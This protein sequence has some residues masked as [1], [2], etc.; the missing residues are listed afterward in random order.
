MSK[1]ELIKRYVL[2][3]IGLFF[4]G[5]GVAIT[6][7]GDLGVTPI[8]SIPNIVSM[9]TDVIS[10]GMLLMTWNCILVTGQILILRKNFKIVNL[11]QIPLSF[12]FGYFTDLGLIMARIIPT[13]PYPWRLFCVVAGTICLGYGIALQVVADTI[14]NSGEAFVKAV[15][16]T[17]HK[18]FGNIKVV[19][20][21]A[22]VSVAIILSLIFF[23]AV[24][25]TR[26]GTIIAA[27]SL[28]F[29]VKFITPRIKPGLEKMLKR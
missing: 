17:I 20:D 13:D 10:F 25:G 9:K 11:L 8:S 6:K 1:K 22:N 27:L 2:F 5:L 29:V 26:E 18:E 3:V 7:H 14:L 15:S 24:K 28:G 4:S 12:L 23:S 21:V 16:D 19:F